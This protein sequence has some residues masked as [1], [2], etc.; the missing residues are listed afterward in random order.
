M[1]SL[2]DETSML[3]IINSGEFKMW[4]ISKRWF[5]NKLFLNEKKK[6]I[7]HVIARCFSR[8]TEPSDHTAQVYADTGRAHV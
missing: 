7:P 1:V 6:I 2:I 5:G 8:D 3:T 4:L